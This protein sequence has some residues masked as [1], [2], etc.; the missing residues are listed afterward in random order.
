LL[1]GVWFMPR[2]AKELGP[3]SIG[4]LTTPGFHFVGGVAGLALQV[5]PTGRRSW[6]LREIVG[7]KRRNMGLG[8]YPDVTLAAAKD[9]ARAARALIDAGTDPIAARATAQAALRAVE[10]V[11]AVMLFR[12]AAATYIGLKEKGWSSKTSNDWTQTLNAYANPIIGDI[13]VNTIALENIIDVLRPIWTTKT[14]TATKVRARIEEILS[15]CRVMKHRTGDNPAVWAGNISVVFASPSK[16]APTIHREAMSVNDVPAFVASLRQ[17]DSMFA[18][19]LEFLIL[20]VVRSDNVRL[21]SRAD[22]DIERKLW[23]IPAA[24]MKTK[25]EHRVPLSGRALEIVETQPRFAEHNFLFN[26]R[27]NSAFSRGGLNALMTDMK[28]EAVPHGF[29]STFK[30]WASERTNYPNELTELVL[31]HAV[32]D[33]TE[34]A[35]RRG[36]MYEKRVL[37]MQDWADYCNGG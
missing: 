16:I 13:D 25:R 11:A 2:K 17:S 24:Q 33:Q 28:L 7:G 30:D 34:A 3:L 19:P 21:A 27:D 8:G 29:R 22:I 4:R 14:Q 20:T 9:A 31:A 26:G 36:D 18:R 15:W 23:T 6:I 1:I 37:L 35:Y 5:L 10:P 12:T 32:A